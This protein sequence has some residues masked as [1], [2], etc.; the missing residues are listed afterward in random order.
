MA[1]GEDEASVNKER[2][3][4]SCVCQKLNEGKVLGQLTA[5]GF[6]GLV[7]SFF[8]HLIHVRSVLGEKEEVTPISSQGIPVARKLM[9]SGRIVETN[10]PEH[11]SK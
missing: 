7:T 5:L 3:G 1:E 4:H 6:A 8:F 2:L 10:L 9:L 11:L